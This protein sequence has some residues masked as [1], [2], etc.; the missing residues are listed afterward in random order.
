MDNS[1]KLILKDNL[2]S[3][4]FFYS[5]FAEKEFAVTRGVFSQQLMTLVTK[6]TF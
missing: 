5:V 1:E 4:M 3:E 6:A 2:G